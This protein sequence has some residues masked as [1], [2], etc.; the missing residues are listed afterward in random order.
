MV[1]NMYTSVHIQA[2]RNIFQNF[3]TDFILERNNRVAYT[4]GFD[5]VWN[6]CLLKMIVLLMYLCVYGYVLLN[7]CNKL[8]SIISLVKSML[9]HKHIMPLD[10]INIIIFSVTSTLL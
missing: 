4:T 3:D 9:L 8:A 10:S 1:P 2:Q 6:G 5:Y 7:D